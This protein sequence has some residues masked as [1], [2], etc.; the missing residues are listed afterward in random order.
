[1]VYY[2]WENKRRDQLAIEH[3]ENSEFLDMTDRENL[4]FRVSF[5]VFVDH[6][7]LLTCSR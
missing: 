4:E 6:R 1:M 2:A 5:D 3:K 7:T